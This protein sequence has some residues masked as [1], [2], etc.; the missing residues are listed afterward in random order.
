MRVET[1]LGYIILIGAVFFFAAWRFFPL[2]MVEKTFYFGVSLGFTLIG[3][4][5]VLQDK[6]PLSQTSFH[7]SGASSVVSLSEN[8]EV[9][10]RRNMEQSNQRMDDTIIHRSFGKTNQLSRMKNNREQTKTKKGVVS[11]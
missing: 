6:P 4:F 1:L 2:S 11:A 10:D 8:G 5:L 9:L 3:T 7:Y